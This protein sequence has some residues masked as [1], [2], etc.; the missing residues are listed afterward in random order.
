MTCTICLVVDKTAN[1]ANTKD[2][3]GKWSKNKKL[4]DVTLETV[5]VAHV[6]PVY[7]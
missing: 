2:V 3:V 5:L 1:F 6:S 7:N 4:F